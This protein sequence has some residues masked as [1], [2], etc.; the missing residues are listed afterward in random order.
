MMSKRNDPGI[1]C[2]N[3]GCRLDPGER[4]DCEEIEVRQKT[5]AEKAKTRRIIAH[6]MR[7]MEKADEEW[8]FA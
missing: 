7:M 4:C 1:R 3:C 2:V 5:A 6:N 8:R